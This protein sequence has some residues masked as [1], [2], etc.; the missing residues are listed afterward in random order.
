MSGNL[1][2]DK[3]RRRLT[4][5]ARYDGVDLNGVSRFAVASC[6]LVLT[7][8]GSE[9]SACAQRNLLGKD[10]FEVTDDLQR[11]PSDRKAAQQLQE[12]TR[13]A[14]AGDVAKIRDTLQMLQA[15][16]TDESSNFW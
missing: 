7:L 6:L 1:C 9:R 8:I 14:R 15:A 11:L 4:R 16:D 5:K 13:L 2:D 3:W 12:L 10:A